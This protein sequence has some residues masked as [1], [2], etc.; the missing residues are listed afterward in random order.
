MSTAR[1]AGRAL[2]G[3]AYAVALGLVGCGA[4]P[5]D[6][7]PPASPPPSST[8]HPGE[9][10]ASGA[11]VA[12][13][14]PGCLLLDTGNAEYLL[15][16]GDRTRLEPGHRVEVRGTPHPGT[17]TTCMQGIPFEVRDVSRPGQP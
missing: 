4:T 10:T 1:F 7:G 14:E 16:G 11:V 3:C 2:V 13:V 9:I 12:G 15:L 8:S 17:P 5:P 6:T